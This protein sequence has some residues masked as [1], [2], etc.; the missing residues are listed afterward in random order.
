MGHT[1]GRHHAVAQGQEMQGVG[2]AQRLASMVM[3]EDSRQGQWVRRRA[4]ERFEGGMQVKQKAW[5]QWQ[6]WGQ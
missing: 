1:L 4:L 6:D 2:R 5:Q 3:V